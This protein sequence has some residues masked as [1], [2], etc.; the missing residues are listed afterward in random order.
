MA[1]L[2]IKTFID[3]RDAGAVRHG[4]MALT[5]F[6][7]I[8]AA[9]AGARGIVTDFTSDSSGDHEV[10]LIWTFS[11]ATDTLVR[12]IEELGTR[13]CYLTVV[14]DDDAEYTRFLPYAERVLDIFS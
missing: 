4:G 12:F 1:A 6:A 8:L 14:C 9:A 3:S 7:P 10:A 11:G 13:A 5:C 2:E